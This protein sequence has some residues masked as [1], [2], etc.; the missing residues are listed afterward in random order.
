MNV[1]RGWSALVDLAALIWI[2]LFALDLSVTYGLVAIGTSRMLLV[3]LLL[4]AMLVVFLTDVLLLYRWSD[5][6]PRPFV[7]TNWFYILTVVPWFRPLRIL[8]AGRVFHSLRVLVRSR[9]FGS[10]LNKVRRTLE[11]AWSRLFS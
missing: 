5:Q 4:R 3:G 6:A 9:R 10:F 7:R 8:R 1:K 2:V 11:G